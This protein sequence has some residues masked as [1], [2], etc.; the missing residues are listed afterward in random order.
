MTTSNAA[1]PVPPPETP[2]VTRPGDG[3]GVGEAVAGVQDGAPALQRTQGTLKLTFKR[4]APGTVLDR[5][6]QEGAARARMPRV[7]GG[8][9]PEAVLINTAG[10]LTG[11]DRFDTEVRVRAGARAVVTTQASEKIY[12]ASS[13]RTT[14]VNRVH[15]E[16]GASLE[17]LPQ[18]AI[19]FDG[20]CL[21]RTLEVS[22]DEGGEALLAEAV[23][24]GRTAMGETVRRGSFVDRWRV[25]RGG[26][27][28]FADGTSLEGDIQEALGRP[29]ALDGGCA[30][31]TIL[32]VSPSAEAGLE[33]FRD[34]M[35]IGRVDPLEGPSVEQGGPVLSA[36]VG[37]SAWD[38]LLSVRIA[39]K[40][41]ASLRSAVE[42]ALGAL[43]RGRPL[44]TVWR[45]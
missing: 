37:A 16:A 45:C 42:G 27:L 7:G 1:H 30:F 8:G 35:G 19:V 33:A 9:P 24:F 41:G 39:A 20:A 36:W 14:I 12:R 6:F 26:T 25:R 29:L 11:G 23:V 43:R 32:W 31:A 21:D 3:S 5:L 13:G 22:L 4:G 2:S 40:D 28:V 17:W 34:A 38:G 44:P 10:G 18:E 15:V